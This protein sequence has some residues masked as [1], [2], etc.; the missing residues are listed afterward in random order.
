MAGELEVL[1]KELE[2]FIDERNRSL[3]SAAATRVF[4]NI[5][6]AAPAVDLHMLIAVVPSEAS[7]AM[8][9]E[10]KEHVDE[11]VE[12]FCRDAGDNGGS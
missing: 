1:P 8:T 9:Q 6:L 7:E 11:L 10:V 3:L 2:D 4:S 12:G 5:R